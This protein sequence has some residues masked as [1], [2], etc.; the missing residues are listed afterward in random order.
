MTPSKSIHPDRIVGSLPELPT[1]G[2]I[3]GPGP[4]EGL[5]FSLSWCGEFKVAG[6]PRQH[7]IHDFSRD[8]IVVE[9]DLGQVV[10]ERPL[11]TRVDFDGAIVG[12]AIAIHL[13]R[14][15]HVDGA[16]LRRTLI[17]SD[18]ALW[19]RVHFPRRLVFPRG[20]AATAYLPLTVA[21]A[22]LDIYY[23]KEGPFLVLEASA[24]IDAKR[25][26][27]ITGAARLLLTYLT[28]ERFD[29]DSCD[30]VAVAASDFVTEARWHHGTSIHRHMYHPT[31]MTWTEVVAAHHALGLPRAAST[32]DPAAVSTCLEYLLANPRVDTSLQ[33]LIRFA[34]APVEMRG[35]FLAVALESF[36]DHLVKAGLLADLHLLP[37]TTWDAVRTALLSAAD[38]ACAG[39]TTEQRKILKDR[40][41]GLNNPTNNQ[42]LMQPF[43]AV[44]VML[45]DEQKK[46]IQRRNKLLHQGRLLDPEVVAADPSAWR[47]AYATEMHLYTAVN[48]LLLKRL[49]YR[50][51]IIDWGKTSIDT[52]EQSY[53]VL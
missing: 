7:R 45:N 14:A 8:D 34:N 31:P 48:A 22:A 43:E 18:D 2:A 53:A 49:G 39:C 11:I 17:R 44:G 3:G 15:G 23:L 47:G 35:A 51:P 30:V 5:P 10:L 50:G 12:N 19:S 26:R 25:Y 42:K 21:G 9:T 33:Y 4:L 41:K 16:K 13:T 38:A 40:I 6:P 46:A 36:T 24:D 32:L 27:E 37:E 28:G 1:L 29:A 52:G 20:G